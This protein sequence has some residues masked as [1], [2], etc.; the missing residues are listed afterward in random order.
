[1]YRV[2][3]RNFF[4]ATRR[5][6]MNKKYIIRLSDAEREQCQLVVKK[7]KGTSQKVKR[8]QILL[9]SDADG[10]SWTDE[11]IADAFN[12]RTRT[13]QKLRQRV[14]TSSFLEA[15]NGKKRESPP[16]ACK[17]DG[18]GEAKLISMRLGKPPAGFGRWT[19]Q[20]LADQLVK[21]EIVEAICAETV[22]KTLK[23]TG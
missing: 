18:E 15:L 5:F 3:M 6:A 9:K 11:K 14:C 2:N 19:L 13:I 12:C 4:V 16:T 7:L 17:L 20:L 8:A 21:L 1:M 10:P 23:K 22:R